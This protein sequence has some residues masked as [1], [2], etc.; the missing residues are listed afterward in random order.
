MLPASFREGNPSSGDRSG[1]SPQIYDIMKKNLFY[2]ASLLL[3]AATFAG[4]SNEEDAS[5]QQ[6]AFSVEAG[7]GFQQSRTTLQDDNETVVWSKGDQIYLFGGNSN[8]TMTLVEGEGETTGTFRG[9]VNGFTSQLTHALYPVP[10]VSGNAYSFNFPAEI[11]YSE[12]SNAPMLGNYTD[13]SVQFGN[14]TAMVR[15]PLKNLDASKENVVTLTMT[16]ITGTAT[17]NVEEGTLEFPTTGMGNAVTVTIPAGVT[18]CFVDVPVPAKA[19][20]GFEVKLNDNVIASK[21][22]DTAEE[23]T[24]EKTAIVTL[25]VIGGEDSELTPEEDGSYVITDAAGLIRFAQQVNSGET[26]EDETVKLGADIDLAGFDWTPIEGIMEGST[27]K[28]FKGTFDG[29]EHTIS[30][31]TVAITG[32]ASA[33][34]F[35]DCQGTIKN[36]KLQNVNISGNYKAGA[37][38]G[39]GLC[40]KIENCHVNGG[41]ITSTPY[42][43]DD[44]NNVGG[45]VGYLSAELEAYVKNCS[46]TGLTITAYRDVAGIVGTAN[47]SQVVIEKNK[48]SN[49][50]IIADQTAGYI[51]VKAANAGEIVGRNLGG[52]DLTTNTFENVTVETLVATAAQLN[53]ALADNSVSLIVLDADIDDCVVMKSNKTIDGRDYKLGSV[54]LNG[55]KNVT[56]KDITFDAANAV[57]SYDYKGNEKQYAN[58]ISGGEDKNTIGV[59]GLVIDGCTFI[60]TFEDGGVSIAFTDQKRP[61]GGSGDITIKNCEF[62]TIGAYYHIYGYY[63]GFGNLVIERNTFKTKGQ[64]CIIYLGRYQSNVPVVVK[65]NGFQVSEDLEGAVYLQSHSNSYDV[66]IN[67]SENTFGDN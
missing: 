64:G 53:N 57:M 26:F 2:A 19:Y 5:L 32:K 50:T 30:N 54:N 22:F 9:G 23:L 3:A 16:G 34:L 18:E 44:A 14:L 41:T 66:S 56:L 59:R 47:M 49:T 46:V 55:A 27:K 33:G 31:L 10:T 11:T 48:V 6:D 4:C 65:G 61:S 42:N 40:S 21:T 62:K 45:I 12:N 63:F 39:N 29:Q 35:A 52:A 20:D 25:G 67:A 8:A 13:G 1:Q 7:I 15:I 36:L 24:T 43:K 37:F 38:V 51:E 58:I 60:G 28:V 17:V